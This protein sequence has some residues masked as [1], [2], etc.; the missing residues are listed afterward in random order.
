MYT[1]FGGINLPPCLL[2][3]GGEGREASAPNIWLGPTLGFAASAAAATTRQCR[4]L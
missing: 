3:T 1:E 4:R 2:R